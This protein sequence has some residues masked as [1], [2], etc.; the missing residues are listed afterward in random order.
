MPLSF[1]VLKL[2]ITQE[3][4]R[5][6]LIWMYLLCTVFEH[7]QYYTMFLG[8]LKKKPES[9]KHQKK[10]SRYVSHAISLFKNGKLIF[11]AGICS[12]SG[13][14]ILVTAIFNIAQKFGS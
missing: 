8:S 12:D 2:E 14:M 7:Y 1:A 9:P 13:S 10:T 11:G 4:Y 5:N 3:R 6:T